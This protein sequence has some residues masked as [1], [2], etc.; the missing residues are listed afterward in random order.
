M[1]RAGR[2]GTPV[3]AVVPFERVPEAVELVAGRRA[4]GKV[5]VRGPTRG[6]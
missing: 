5:V 2:L 6:G 3:H 1:L 4:M